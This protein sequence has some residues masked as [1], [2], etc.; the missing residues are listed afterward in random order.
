MHLSH[1]GQHFWMGNSLRIQTPPPDQGC[2][3][4]RL[5][6]LDGILIDLAVL[7]HFYDLELVS[8]ANDVPH[9]KVALYML[10]LDGDQ[11]NNIIRIIS[12]P[13][14]VCSV[15]SWMDPEMCCLVLIQTSRDASALFNLWL[16]WSLRSYWAW[17]HRFI[18]H[19]WWSS[20]LLC[21]RPYVKTTHMNLSRPCKEPLYQC[22]VFRDFLVYD[23]WHWFGSN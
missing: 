5:L 4:H 9:S 6:S 21:L 14:K 22:G 1:P 23:K 10:G 20:D 2:G 12:F 7:K 3:S 8:D 13:L 19:I 17:A 18:W 15:M 16:R 11:I